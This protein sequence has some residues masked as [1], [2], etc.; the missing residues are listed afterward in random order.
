[1]TAEEATALER[2]AFIAGRDAALA[3]DIIGL[4]WVLDEID[5]DEGK[6]LQ[7]LAAFS[8]RDLALTNLVITFSWVRDDVTVDEWPALGSLAALAERDS[9][10]AS[11]VLAFNWVTDAIAAHERWTL[12]YLNSIATSDLALARHL[13]GL[14][15]IAD[16]ISE[17]ERGALRYIQDIGL[18][19]VS[20]VS[21]AASVPWITDGIVE[22][23]LWALMYLRDIFERDWALG[24]QLVSMP[25][26]TTSFELHDRQALSALGY[27]GDFFPDELELLTGRRWF[28][29]GLDDQEAALVVVLGAPPVP[30]F[31]PPDLRDLTRTNYGESRM[32]TYAD[33]SLVQLTFFQYQPDPRKISGFVDQVEETIQIMAEF[34]GVQ[35]PVEEVILLFA[36]PTELNLREGEYVPAFNAG[37]VYVVVDPT[38]TGQQDTLNHEIAH[39][40]W[41]SAEGPHWFVE[42]GSDF[43]ASYVAERLY[44][45]SP[46][47]PRSL[48]RKASEDNGSRYCGTLSI[49]TIQD[50]I[51]KLAEEGRAIHVE[52]A[53]DICNYARGENLF[54]NLYTTIGADSFR[55]A[56]NEL[57]QLAQQEQRPVTEEEIYQAFLRNTAANA[58]SEFKELYLSLHGGDFGS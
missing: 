58:V 46:I 35:F 45:T 56:W 20:G 19:D 36:S 22:D 9:T 57:Y 41:G 25:F 28:F 30:W 32:A 18:A 11:R 3:Q 8:A 38:E 15:W 23:E 31:G 53:Y 14:M 52:Q 51:D 54:L 27:L 39:Y 26:Y 24:R 7:N 43:L 42:G 47:D 55:A 34:I 16:D 37:G 21:P 1:M 2:F 10:L 5:E 29:D 48:R 33:G 12:S 49:D 40:Y 13:S 50:L 17:D 6:A 44:S 4:T